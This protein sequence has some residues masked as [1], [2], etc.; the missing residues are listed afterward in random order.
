MTVSSRVLRA[1]YPVAGGGD[2]LEE[3]L[4]ETGAQVESIVRSEVTAVVGAHTGPGVVGVALAPAG[5]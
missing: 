4:T 5:R 3:R 1:V 2:A